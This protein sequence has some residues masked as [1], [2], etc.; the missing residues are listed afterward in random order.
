[1]LDSEANPCRRAC[2]PNLQLNLLHRDQP[3]SQCDKAISE[4]SKHVQTAAFLHVGGSLPTEVHNTSSRDSRSAREQGP[5]CPLPGRK[6]RKA[7]YF[8]GRLQLERRRHAPSLARH[9]GG[10]LQQPARSAAKK[11]IAPW[12]SWGGWRACPA[13]K[14]CKHTEHRTMRPSSLHALT[15]P[16]LLSM[17]GVCN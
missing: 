6:R 16:R 9:F 14:C 2:E 1:M 15:V 10:H 12:A 5:C 11:P 3:L 4:P 8:E 13:S 7:F 17:R